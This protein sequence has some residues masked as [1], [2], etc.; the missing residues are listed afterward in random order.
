VVIVRGG[1][2]CAAWLAWKNRDGRSK[3]TLSVSL[4]LAG[5]K[6]V[7]DTRSTCASPEHSYTFTLW[8]TD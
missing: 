6:V 7:I 1:L 4:R 5:F 8:M 2:P 3:K